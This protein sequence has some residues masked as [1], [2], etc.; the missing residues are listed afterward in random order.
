MNVH[1]IPPPENFGAAASRIL[2][3]QPELVPASRKSDGGA[4]ERSSY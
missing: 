1:R 2:A 4:A 3:R